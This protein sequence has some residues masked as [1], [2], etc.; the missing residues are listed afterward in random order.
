MTTKQKLT[1]AG[2]MTTRKSSATASLALLLTKRWR[3][4]LPLPHLR[5]RVLSG[6]SVGL[7][8]GI[9]PTGV[10]ADKHGKRPVTVVQRIAEGFVINGA[11]Q[12]IEGAI[13]YLENP[14][15]LD[16]KSY[17]TDGKGHFHFTQLAAQTDYEVWAEQNGVQT[18]HK[19]IS[20]FSS[21]NHFE[22]TLKLVPEHK[23]KLLG[24]L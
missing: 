16:I 15:S 12:P 2:T 4:F 24:I 18:K 9:A 14:T 10:W 5:L 13:V 1:R 6:I 8:L 21:H 20:Q 3:P 11:R 7:L 22:F 17:L 23:K 19:F